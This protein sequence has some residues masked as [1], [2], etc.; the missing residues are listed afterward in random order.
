M[1]YTPETFAVHHHLKSKEGSRAFCF[2]HWKHSQL[3]Y[4][5]KYSG[6]SRF[7]KWVSYLS[8]HCYFT[9]LKIY[10]WLYSKKNK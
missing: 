2:K 7:G 8:I 4:V 10:H 6:L 5:R 1:F 3:L 9:T